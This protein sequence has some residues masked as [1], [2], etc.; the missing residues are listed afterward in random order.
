MAYSGSGRMLRLVVLGV[1]AQVR[2]PA[3]EAKTPPVLS[4]AVQSHF[5][6]HARSKALHKEQNRIIKWL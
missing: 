5:G 1:R 3:A 6:A 2:E 4:N